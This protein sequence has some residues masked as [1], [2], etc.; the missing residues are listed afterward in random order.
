[1]NKEELKS[2]LEKFDAGHCT[3]EEV[4]MLESWYL[5]W[6]TD[7]EIDLADAE[8]EQRID[9]IWSRLDEE[10][11][12]QKLP[13]RLWPRFAAAAVLL[14]ALSSG[15]F[16]YFNPGGST[17]ARIA[18]QDVP[19]GGNKAYL[20]LADGK[21]IVLNNAA[22]GQLAKETGVAISK[23]ADGRL[24][25]TLSDQS[26]AR[27]A[28]PIYNKIETPKGGQYQI[29]LPDGTKVWLNS[30][31]SLRFPATFT[32]VKTR[33]VELSGE[34]YFE[35]AHNKKL[36]FIVKTARQELSVLGTHFNLSS[37]ADEDVTKTTLLEG[38]VLIH[39]L[40]NIVKPVEGTDFVVLKPGQQANLRN[41]IQ[42]GPADIEMATAWKEGNFFFNALDLKSILKQ[43]SRWYNVEVDYSHVPEN[44]FFTVFISRSVNLSKVLEMFEKTGGIQFE[45]DHKT[46]KV[47]NLKH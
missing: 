37:Y 36:P 2:L 3:A 4:G 27:N 28:E 17:P 6:R 15:L 5:Q 8:A 42:T 13:L 16:F 39:R 22:N 18:K 38:A 25:Y 32:N 7:E 26:I 10:A 19:A 45:I 47:I 33:E 11:E 35:V 29:V 46:I 44:R 1:M 21:R 43:L 40:G 30:A 24:V 20:T 23:S 14:I 34:A 9:H 12:V 41:T 31:S